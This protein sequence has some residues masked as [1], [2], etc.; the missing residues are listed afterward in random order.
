MATLVIRHPDGSE[1]EHELSGELKIGRQEGTNDLVLAEGGVSRRHARFFEEGGKVLVEDVGSANGTFVDGTRITG[2]TPLTPKSQVLVGDYEVRL[3]AS[4]RAT[5]SGARK[6]AKP[7]GDEPEALGDANPRA[8]RAMPAAKRPAPGAG[9]PSALAKRPRPAPSAADE[10][11][12]PPV[13]KGL[14]GPW[15]NQ[16]FP[17]KGKLL[18]GRQVPASVV[19]EDDS[20]SRK[21]AE[22]EATPQGVVLRDLGSANGTLVNG[23]P[24]GTEEVVLQPGD[25]ISF[26][27]VELVL[28]SGSKLPVRGSRGDLPTRRGAGGAADAEAPAAGVPASRKKLLVVAASVVGLLLVAGI[29]KN[30]S[31]GGGG[32]GVS[33][34]RPMAQKAPPP[35]SPAEQVQEMLSQCRSYASRE[36]G[37]EPDWVKAEAACSK[38]LDIDPINAE[39]NT[40]MRRIKVEK[41]AAENFTQGEKALA[42]S[43]EVEALELFRKIPK[44]SGYFRRAKPKVLEAVEKVAKRAQDDCKRYLRDS[45]WSTA[46][47]QCEQ[48]MGYA[49]QKMTKEELEPPIGF[50]L[51]LDK[52]RRL[53]R[54]EWRPKDKLYLDFLNARHRVMPDAAPWRCPVSDIFMVDEAAPDPKVQVEATFKQRLPNKFMIAAMM[55]YYGGRG[56]EAVATLQRLRNN[57]ELSQY[58][59]Q[60]DKLIADVNNVDQL[61]KT[62]QG[63]LQKEEVEKAEEP[64]LEALEVDKRLMGDLAETK[65][66]FYRRNIQHD[67]ASAAIARGKY[68]DD[69]GDKRRSCRIWKLGF[70]FYAGNTDLNSQVGRCSTRGLSAIKEASSCSELDVVLDYAVPGD[71]LDERVAAM[72]KELGC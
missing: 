59:S 10:G 58:H 62:G 68:W 6:A 26:G 1:S 56:N 50:T 53:G 64:L 36:L 31:G 18:V 66:S 34:T 25:V 13:L 43:K 32:G 30:V 52:N 35:Q 55:D 8:T 41:E 60:A 37:G 69:R 39:A 47:P 28:E 22:V 11:G 48:Y 16:K 51:V 15:A 23:E 33:G 63:Y 70:R 24:V 20:V 4:T 40:L 17:V 21:H 19:L 42:R 5:A 72:K 3:K 46:V 44:D 7:A 57:Y 14:T 38:A 45:Q 67:M 54:N 61:F 29:V 27:M 65:P 2:M 71:G 49:C 12:G 9:G